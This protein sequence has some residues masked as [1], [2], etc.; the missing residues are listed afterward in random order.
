[1]ATV[2]QDPPRED[3]SFTMNLSPR[4]IF[5]ATQQTPL[6]VYPNL[7]GPYPSMR[8]RR[9]QRFNTEGSI[10][11]TAYASPMYDHQSSQLVP[12]D[13]RPIM[14]SQQPPTQ[15]PSPPQS[16][17]DPSPTHVKQSSGD[18]S[19]EFV[20]TVP[21]FS[22]SD[23]PAPLRKPS[24]YNPWQPTKT[25]GQD[26]PPSQ[27]S[28]RSVSQQ[29]GFQSPGN[30]AGHPSQ[31]PPDNP[32]ITTSPSIPAPVSSNPRAVPLS[33]RFVN[34]PLNGTQNPIYTRSHMPR[35]EVCLECAMRDQDM[36]DV[37]VTSPGV[38]ER[39]S[40]VY[41]QDLIRSEEEAISTGTPI[42]EDSPRSTGDLLTETNLKL[43]LTMVLFYTRLNHTACRNLITAFYPT[44]STGAGLAANEFGDICSSPEVAHRSRDPRSRPGDAGVQG[45]GKQNA[46]YIFAHT[47]ICPRD[48]RFTL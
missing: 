21:P 20:D 24:L 27:G 30:L 47:P 36:A 14:S 26:P 35:E 23:T 9:S 16:F 31:Q 46:R 15:Q 11:L 19:P 12:T 38:W 39:D 3:Q 29:P 1:M 37:D 34:A 33:P 32:P 5:N 42:P 8:E 44:E 41:Y 13:H 22:N 45:T 6:G 28:A 43:W 4:H 2:V 18:K 10:P 25:Y 17:K 7:D 40:D 48:W